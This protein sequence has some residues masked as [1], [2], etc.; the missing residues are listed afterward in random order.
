MNKRSIF[1]LTILVILSVVPVA[2]QSPSERLSQ[3][4]QAH[5]NGDASRAIPVLNEL[6]ASGSLTSSEVSQARK[7]LGLGH[8]LHEDE[9]AAVTVFKD[10]VGSDPDFTMNDLAL[11]Y[12]D[13]PDEYAVRFFAQA[14]LEWRQEQLQR[15]RERLESTSRS[16]VLARSLVLPGLGQRYQGY[17][18]RSWAMLGLTGAAVAYA[19]I[20]DN[21][22]RDAKDAYDGGQIGDDFEGLWRDYSDKA[23][24]ADLA[25][26]IVGAVWA[27]N[28]VDAALSGPNLSGLESVHVAPLRSSPG[29]MQLALRKEF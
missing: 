22:Y 12:E 17:R 18:G 15:Q 9:A 19:V 7:Y 10:L 16:G 13:A 11:S 6:L 27:L 23:D 25:V 24:T 14:T 28:L 5:E 20:A 8:L 29:G 4:I 26:A 1:T 3:A 2:A 21:S